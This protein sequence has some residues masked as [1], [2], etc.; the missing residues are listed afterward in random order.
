MNIS[1][2]IAKDDEAFEYLN[3][4]VTVEL[5]A[6]I[7]RNKPNTAIRKTV[8][9]LLPRINHPRVKAIMI[10]LAK[11]SFPFGCLLMLRRGL[12][13]CVDGKISFE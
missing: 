4:L 12:E 10:G 1:Q 7:H 9:R 13:E 3:V 11:Q 8:A 5:A 2:V 6:E